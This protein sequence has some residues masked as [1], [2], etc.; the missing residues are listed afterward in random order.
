MPES[1]DFEIKPLFSGMAFLVYRASAGSGKTY[2]L[3]RTYLAL[4]LS[5]DDPAHFRHILAITFTNKAAQEMKSRIIAALAEIAGQA[6]GNRYQS[7]ASDL[8]QQLDLTPKALKYRAGRVFQAILHRYQDFSISTI[9]AF[10]AR[11]GRSFARDLRL[12]QGFEIVLDQQEIKQQAVDFLLA[13]LGE[14]AAL[15][16]TLVAFALEQTADDKSWDIRKALLGYCQELFKDESRAYLPLLAQIEPAEFKNSRQLLQ[17]RI[18][19]FDNELSNAGNSAVKLID[20]SGLDISCFAG[21]SRGIYSFF[22]KCAEFKFDG[23]SAAAKKTYEEDKWAGSKIKKA[24]VA[25]LEATAAALRPLLAQI[26]QLVEDQWPKYK[27]YLAIR[28][29]L[30]ATA[31][32]GQLQDAVSVVLEEQQA[33]TLSELYHRIGLLLA[34]AATPFIYERLGNRYQHFLIDEFQDTSILQWQ[35]LAPLVDNGLAANQPSLLVGDAK[36]AIYRWRSGEAG[37]FVNL[38]EPY[39]QQ[40]SYPSFYNAFELHTLADNYRSGKEIIQFNNSF[41]RHWA[42]LLATELQPNYEALEQNPKRSGGYVEVQL[43]EK[44]KPVQAALDAR[45]TLIIQKIHELLALGFQAGDMAVLVRK[46]KTGSIVAGKLLQEGLPVIS[47]DSLLLGSHQDVQFL[48]QLIRWLFKNDKIADAAIKL[49][50]QSEN[51]APIEKLNDYFKQLHPGWHRQQWLALPLYELAENLLDFFGLNQT[52]DPFM[53]A[54]L[55]QLHQFSQQIDATVDAWLE[56]WDEKGQSTAVTLPEGLNA[57]QVMTIHKSKGLEFPVVF[58]PEPDGGSGKLGVA[59]HWI[60]T[61]AEISLPIAY[62]ELSQLKESPPEYASIFEQE[63]Q[64][65]QLDIVNNIYVACT[66]A[67]EALFIYG[68]IPPRNSRATTLGFSAAFEQFVGTAEA[69]AS[70]RVYGSLPQ[71]FVSRLIETKQGQ[72]GQHPFANWREHLRLSTRFRAAETLED[73]TPLRRGRLAHQLL[74]KLNKLEDL[75]ELFISATE[76]GQLAAEDAAQM[77]QVLYDILHQ[78]ALL[79]YFDP[80]GQVLNEAAILGP[81]THLRPDHVLLVGDE[82]RVLE[83]KTGQALPEH[84]TQLQKYLSLLEEMGY[85]A[86][87]Q[88]VYLNFT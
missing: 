4:A 12:Q 11:I 83:Y 1:G 8:S 24:D 3:V 53:A 73:D 26:I 63:Q 76:E 61:P 21:G 67:S 85:R 20:A 55:D 31:T 30:Y 7:M 70:K 62:V 78:P 71:S 25:T 59:T 81:L 42:G 39:G 14:D 16:E 9:D 65:T 5:G 37:Q 77:Q 15:T 44:S 19:A 75:H 48:V 43:L 45:M 56:W 27:L 50:L 41:F 88:L 86:S 68:T 49:R 17:S 46:N 23:I 28:K 47:A 74:A 57:I 72:A 69:V 35:N 36:Q 60:K 10:V 52:A 29:T 58:I 33:T 79:P 34:D 84:N 51:K 40:P 87:G 66:R 13:Q 18:A 6:E 32:L 2:T 80:L 38:P 22:K 64:K 54:L 82:A